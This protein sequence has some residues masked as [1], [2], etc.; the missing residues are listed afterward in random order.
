MTIT[1]KISADLTALNNYPLA[2]LTTWKAGGN[3]DWA[4]LPKS[5]L[6]IRESCM[7]AKKNRLPITVLGGGSNVLIS[8]KGVEGLTIIMKEFTGVTSAS[9]ALGALRAEC[10]AGTPKSDLLKLFIKHRLSP[11]I[12]LAGLPGDVGGGVVMNAGI[13]HDKKPKEFSEIIDWVEYIDLTDPGFKIVRK[14]KEELE[15]HYRQ[16]V[17]WRPGIV[18][19]VGI[20]WREDPRDDVL[21]EVQE[22]NKR[23]MST[24]PL[25]SPSCGSV[26]KNPHSRKA[27]Q[28]IEQSGLK[29]F[30][31][32]GAQVSEKHANFIINTGKATAADITAVREHVQKV[33]LEQTRIPLDTEYV[34]IGRV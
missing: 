34:F 27:G 24:Q 1:N 28:L 6:H 8:D 10:W 9:Y 2:P 21:Q 7:W 30:T 5:V 4:V 33:V 25:Q 16:S 13:G 20:I 11:A 22:G 15:W 29:G 18:T 3:A 19:Q 32:G 23:R 12:F 17:G 31:I 26:F 14:E